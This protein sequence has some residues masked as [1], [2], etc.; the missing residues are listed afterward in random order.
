GVFVFPVIIRARIG[1]SQ[2]PQCSS[3]V[4]KWAGTPAHIVVRREGS[5]STAF[6]ACH[7]ASG[8]ITGKSF[9]LPSYSAPLWER[10]PTIR[11]DSSSFRSVLLRQ[12]P[13]RDDAI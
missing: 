13:L 2:M 3:P 7:L 1:R 8:R 11:G 10:F 6:T 12:G 4:S 5:S 9:G